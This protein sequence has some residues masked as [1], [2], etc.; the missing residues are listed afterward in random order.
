MLDAAAAAGV[1]AVPGVA[2]GEAG[3]LGRTVV[4]RNVTVASNA[5][6]QYPVHKRSETRMDARV[7]KRE[8]VAKGI[9]A[10]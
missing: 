10:T 4:R 6:C 1:R 3:A 5:I 2:A 8:K 7:W 9:K